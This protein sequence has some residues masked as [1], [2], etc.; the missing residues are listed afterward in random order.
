MRR[1]CPLLTISI[2][3]TPSDGGRANEP[4]IDWECRLVCDGGRI[5]AIADLGDGV[6]VAGSRYPRPGHIYLSCDAGATWTDLGNLLGNEPLT[7]S[8]TCIAA[9]RDRDAFLLTG[10]AHVWRSTDQG[11]TWSRLTRV[12]HSPRL[13]TYQHAY[14]LAVLPSGTVLVS[15]TNP[16]GGHVFRS[17]NRGETWS[18][19]GA[20]SSQALYRFQATRDVVLLNGW[21]GHVYRSIDDGLTWTDCGQLTDAPLYATE[22]VDD[23]CF[24]QGSENGRVLHSSDN[25]T[26]WREVAQFNGAADDFAALDDGIV[27]YSTYTDERNSYLSRD[28]GE[29]WANAGPLPTPAESDVLDHVIGVEFEGERYA[30]GGT[31]HGYIVRWRVND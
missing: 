20:V 15:D 28:G 2:L 7:S 12:S 13:G 31:T 8:V 21:Q 4:H 29:S 6:V 5:D 24:L 1:L 9:G 23:Q 11:Q 27:L 3:C 16:D 17:T 19:V 14:G 26:S 25:G 10:D 30:V 22:L 18:D